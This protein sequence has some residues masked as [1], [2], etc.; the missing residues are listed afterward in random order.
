MTGD[1]I[2][3]VK[4][5]RAWRG[6]NPPQIDRLLRDMAR[7]LDAGI[8]LP[9]STPQPRKFIGKVMRGYDLRAVDSFFDT[10][11]SDRAQ[12]V[13]APG[14][15]SPEI[16]GHGRPELPGGSPTGDRRAEWRGV[17][18]LPGTRLRRTAGLTSKIID[19]D[20]QVLLAHRGRTLRVAAS[21]QVFRNDANR[22]EI[23]DA[24]TGAWVL[25]WIG[26]HS[27]YHAGTVVLGPG[28]RWLSFPI[29]GSR[30]RNAVMRAVDESG[31]EVVWFRN[32]QRVTVEAVVSPDCGIS[33]EIPV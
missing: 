3:G 10:L 28:Q 14:P 17:A 15:A 5:P 13:P 30:F 21:G 25:C 27:Y 31:A 33:P 26:R 12:Q 11:T 32:T 1:A 16:W 9:V 2:R 22:A 19:S 23:V 24:M 29:Q 4:F 18:D 8:P 7:L 20:G 6:Y